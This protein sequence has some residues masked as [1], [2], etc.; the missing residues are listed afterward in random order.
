M[1]N[2][3]KRA[4]LTYLKM[5]KHWLNLHVKVIYMASLI[6]FVVEVVM[7]LLLKHNELLSTSVTVYA[8]NN[9]FFPTLLCLVLGL[10]GKYIVLSH[11]LRLKQK[12]YMLSLLTLVITF[13][14]TM[15]HNEFVAV[16]ILLIV[17]LIFTIF[18]EDKN[19]LYMMGCLTIVLQYISALYLENTSSQIIYRTYMTNVF[20]IIVMTCIVLLSCIMMLHFLEIRKNLIVSNEK[21]LFDLQTKVKIDGLTKVGNKE[22]LIQSLEKMIVEKRACYLAMI[23]IDKF[24][25][26]NDHYGHL[27]GDETLKRVGRVLKENVPENSVFRYGGDEFCIVL[28]DGQK[29][30]YQCIVNIQEKLNTHS[31]TMDESIRM[32]V[33]IAFNKPYLCVD[34]WIIMADKAMY[35]SKSK[36]GNTITFI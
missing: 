10:L 13:M 11:R 17:P 23:D 29:N 25:E 31:R 32:S 9:I 35:Q 12:Q 16:L 30:V 1:D 24:K 2:N 6:H 4:N 20:I 15:I 33:G 8:F 26:F 19:L 18:Y 7:V 3:E 27:C 22:S 21:E 5:S 14:I 34:E 36:G 28:E